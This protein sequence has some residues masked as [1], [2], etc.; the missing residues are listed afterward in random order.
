M[1]SKETEGHDSPATKPAVFSRPRRYASMEARLIANSVLWEGCWL[2]M[3]KTSKR[4]GGRVDGRMT[5]RIAGRHVSRRAHRVSYQEFRGDIP[6]GYEIDHACRN[7]LC[8]NPAHLEA[9]TPEENI[10]RRDR[11]QARLRG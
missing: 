10:V 7:T 3:G 2:W 1:K 9:V 5:L 8:I 4:R 6:D 11:G